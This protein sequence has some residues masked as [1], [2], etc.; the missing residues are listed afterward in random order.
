MSLRLLASTLLAV[1]VPST[2][3]GPS[4]PPP[5]TIRFNQV[6]FAPDGQKRFI[7]ASASARPLA[8]RL[9]GTDGRI[10][11]SGRSVP[12]GF[13][14]PSGER[15]HRIDVARQLAAGRYE[16]HV[17]GLTSRAITV[18]PHPFRGLFGDAMSFFYQQRAGVP[19]EPALVQRPDL[20]R[21]A[22]HAPEVAGCFDG[23]DRQGVRW[24]GCGY[25]LNVTGGWYDAGDHGKYVVNAGVSVWALLNAYE[26]TV[27]RAPRSALIADGALLLPER[28]NGVS[29]L[30]DEARFEIAFLLAMQLPEGARTSVARANRI[31]TIDAGGLVHH[32]VSDIRWTSLPTAPAEDRERRVLFPPSTAATLNLAAVAGQC[33]RIWRLIDPGFAQTCLTAARRAWTA[34]ERE[35]A[36]IAT[37]RFEGSGGYG[38]TDLADERFWAAAELFATTGDSAYRE[39]LLRSSLFR[40]DTPATQ[41]SWLTV[42][43]AGTVTLLTVP[44]K[45]TPAE[46]SRQRRALLAA[47]DADV[48]EIAKQGYAIPF[49]PDTY[50]WGSNGAMLNAATMLGVAYDLTGE[51]IY[52]DAVVD[53]IDYVLGRNPLDRSYVTGYGARPMRNP[54]HRFWAKQADARYPAPP[55][56]VLSGG[57]NDSAMTDDVARP[58]KGRC[59]AQTCWADDHRAFTQNEVAINWNAPLVWVA[60]FL[61]TTEAAP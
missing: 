38:D 25:R 45:L 16:L 3:Q 15:V 10:A 39:A 28:G 8:W 14:K 34:A 6:A 29:D 11:A 44:N 36:L 33:A 12:F 46:L 40:A 31:E 20:A 7:V 18:S 50:P 22:G 49:G 60:A 42:G 2:A 23:V 13:D 51:R 24:P 26:R 4:E 55:P 59:R 41:I 61:D 57:P 21:A 54:H 35:P 52:R 53:T 17:D 19:I 32:K 48:A 47:A 43:G 9:T 1:A 27:L 5:G 30:L 56:G 37:D 58:M